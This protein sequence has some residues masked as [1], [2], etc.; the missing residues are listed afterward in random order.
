[1]ELSRATKVVIRAIK[2]VIRAKKL[3]TISL[4]G[5]KLLFIYV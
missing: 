2:A 4:D 3:A 5:G 1:V